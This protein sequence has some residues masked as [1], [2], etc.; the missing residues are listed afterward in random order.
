MKIKLHYFGEIPILPALQF[1]WCT[2]HRHANEC[3]TGTNNCRIGR[4]DTVLRNSFPMQRIATFKCQ[5]M[6]V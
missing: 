6:E 1:I 5:A 2:V 3:Q 4:I